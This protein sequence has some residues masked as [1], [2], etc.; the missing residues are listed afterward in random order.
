MREA[1]L[2]VNDLAEVQFTMP[3]FPSPRTD[4]PEVL[5]L[6]LRAKQRMTGRSLRPRLPA[7]MRRRVFWD[8]LIISPRDARENFSYYLPDDRTIVLSSE[9]QLQRVLALRKTSPAGPEW[10][11]DWPGGDAAAM[12]NLALFNA[13]V[14]PI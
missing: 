12:V 9:P 6:V 10:A 3:R 5:I 14:G 11:A 8:R 4:E 7:T 13:S 1:Q 2:G